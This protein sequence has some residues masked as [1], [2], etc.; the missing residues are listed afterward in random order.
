MDIIERRD[1]RQDQDGALSCKLIAFR[2]GRGP[3][4]IEFFQSRFAPY[5][6]LA[7]E[8][9]PILGLPTSSELPTDSMLETDCRE[10]GRC[11]T[12]VLSQLFGRLDVFAGFGSAGTGP[13]GTDVG[14]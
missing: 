3:R 2:I 14:G 7:L 11:I 8:D 10:R 5:F 6:S 12:V 13:F 1:F 9:L 4:T